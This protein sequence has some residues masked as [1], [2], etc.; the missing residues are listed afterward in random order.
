MRHLWLFHPS[1]RLVRTHANVRKTVD[2]GWGGGGGLG[3]SERD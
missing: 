3:C 1:G 2:G